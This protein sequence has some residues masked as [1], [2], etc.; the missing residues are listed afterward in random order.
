M[1]CNSRPDSL[2]QTLEEIGFHFSAALH[3]TE[4]LVEGSLFILQTFTNSY[5]NDKLSSQLPSQSS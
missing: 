1:N 5:P 2:S 3:E 4:G